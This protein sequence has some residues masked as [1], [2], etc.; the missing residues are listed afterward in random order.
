MAFDRLSPLAMT[1]YFLKNSIEVKDIGMERQFKT[2]STTINNSLISSLVL[3]E[4]LSV[5]SHPPLNLTA[6]NTSSTSFNV[7]WNEIPN[8]H[9][10]GIILGYTIRYGFSRTGFTNKTVLNGTTRHTELTGLEKYKLYSIQILGF[11]VKGY[12]N[13]SEPV[14]VR[15]A[16]DGKWLN[17]K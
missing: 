3:I 12:G 17:E 10:N 6:Y 16:E 1:T 15:T 9:K 14:I 11:T 7:T 13:L 8:E 4:C 2:F 5:P